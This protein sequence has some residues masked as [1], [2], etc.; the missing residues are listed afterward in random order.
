MRMNGRQFALRASVCAAFLVATASLGGAAP[1]DRRPVD[2]K[3]STGDAEIDRACALAIRTL[4]MNVSEKWGKLCPVVAPAW[5]RCYPA[6]VHV[7]DNFWMTKVTPYLYP[8]DQ[9]EWP[10]I[11]LSRYQWPSGMAEGGIHDCDGPE[12]YQA[13]LARMGPAWVRKSSIE[14]PYLRDHL[15]IMQV[16][17]LWRHYGDAELARSLFPSCR[18]SLDYLYSLKDD[19]KDGL[20]ESADIMEDVQVGSEKERRGPNAAERFVDQALLYG[21]LIDYE[22]LAEAAGEKAEADRARSRLATLKRKVNELY[23][24]DKGYY[25][26]ALDSRTHRPLHAEVASTYANGYAILWGLVPPERVPK[27]LD[28]FTGWDFAVPGPILVP[29]LLDA[30]VASGQV[31][32]PPGVYVN[33]GCGWGRGYL[34]S[35]C[36]ALFRH[37]RQNVA[38]DYLRKMARAANRAGAF[39]EYWTWEKYT[40]TTEP[41]GCRDYSE[42]SSA[43]LDS[44][45]HGYFGIEPLEPGWRSLRFAPQSRAECSITLGLPGGEFTAAWKKSGDRWAVHLGSGAQRVVE[46]A[47]AGARGTKVTV[48]GERVLGDY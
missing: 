11:L 19:D 2:L 36:L 23:W 20:V 6:W 45:I 4:K 46:V 22:K 44:V 37:G 5:G 33:G 40:G 16:H 30:S 8:R 13:Y 18:K 35:I 34:P 41:G 47:P 3:I 48:Q 17:D 15:Y 42:T 25:V 12:A 38:I 21:A 39:Y 43:F 7:F 1:E 9:A 24:N 26:F 10:A 28:Y 32:F 14:N 29:P 31:K 27:M